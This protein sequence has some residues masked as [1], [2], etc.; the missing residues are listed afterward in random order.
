[1]AVIYKKQYPHPT[2]EE[3][4]REWEVSQ[5]ETGASPHPSSG[6]T[7]TPE[8]FYRDLIENRTLILLPEKMRGAK[9]FLRLAIETSKRYRLDTEISREESHITVTYSFSC[10]A[11]MD[12][13]IPILRRADSISFFPSPCGLDITI[14]LDYYTHAVYSKGRLLHPQY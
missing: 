1:M 7:P 5:K 11:D 3:E 9:A 8:D 14:A 13:L 10:S 12:F 2:L 6:P 4:M